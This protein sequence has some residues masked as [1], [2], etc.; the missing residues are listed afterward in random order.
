MIESPNL[1]RT[2]EARIA[3]EAEALV[4]KSC[5]QWWHSVADRDPEGLSAVWA[6]HSKALGGALGRMAMDGL[7]NMIDGL[8]QCAHCPLKFLQ[9]SDEQ[10][11][12]HECLVM[13]M[14]AGIQNGDDDTTW[15]AAER[16]TCPMRAGELIGAAGG[17][18]AR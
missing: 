6:S 7:C 4:L 1:A 13:T 11:G 9:H 8:G 14:I 3:Y 5:R 10:L 2:L 18:A 17:L 15:N 12:E 16:M